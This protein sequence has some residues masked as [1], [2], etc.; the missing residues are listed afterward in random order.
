MY[1]AINNFQVQ[2]G[3]MDELIRVCREQLVPTITQ[4]SGLKNLQV[5]I[6]HNTNSVI[7]IGLYDTEAN[8]VVAP[9]SEAYQDA[10][11]ALRGF[12]A[13]TLERDVYKVAIQ[14]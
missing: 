8:A 1:A 12:L 5:L 13:S 11:E 14:A 6:D 2:P 10:L 3:M 7:L 9:S 4:I